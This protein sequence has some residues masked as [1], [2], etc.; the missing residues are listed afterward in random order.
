MRNR[1]ASR[2]SSRGP[3][4]GRAL[5]SATSSVQPARYKNARRH[6]MSRRS[7]VAATSE[8]AT[9]PTCT[10]AWSH[11]T[12]EAVRVESDRHT[13]PTSS[14]GDIPRNSTRASSPRIVNRRRACCVMFQRRNDST[15]SAGKRLP[16]CQSERM[17]SD[18]VLPA[19]RAL[20][21]P[22]PWGEPRRKQPKSHPSPE[23]ARF[24]RSASLSEKPLPL[25]YASCCRW[26]DGPYC[27]DRPRRSAPRRRRLRP[28]ENRP[29]RQRLARSREPRHPTV[30][31]TTTDDPYVLADLCDKTAP[32]ARVRT[33]ATLRVKDSAVLAEVAARSRIPRSAAPSSDG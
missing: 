32:D 29:R 28:Q 18:I 27:S 15:A 30:I 3:G 24:S 4:G 6:Q 16:S 25:E 11:A 17:F 14:Q 2:S 20:S 9:K 8:P 31:E 33:G 10:R 23:S 21:H 5:T 12:C 26:A 22:F 7:R 19:R 1:E 13:A